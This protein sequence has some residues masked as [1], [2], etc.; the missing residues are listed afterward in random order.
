MTSNHIE[1][2]LVYI[3][4]LNFLLLT[5]FTLCAESHLL[6]CF[7]PSNTNL[8][9]YFSI[10]DICVLLIASFIFLKLLY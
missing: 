2:F 7:R 6:R 1:L 8:R 9:M 4:V 5:A 10:Q 3:Q